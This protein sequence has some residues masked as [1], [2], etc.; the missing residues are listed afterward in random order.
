[1]PSIL[2]NHSSSIFPQE[3][4]VDHLVAENKPSL[5]T[6]C[7]RSIEIQLGY[8]D[9]LVLTLVP[10]SKSF[11]NEALLSEDKLYFRSRLKYESN[12]YGES[13]RLDG[14]AW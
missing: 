11:S 9:H 12:F 5:D 14:A 13:G 6:V 7:G 8:E 4:T 3:S 10:S 2:A 1:M